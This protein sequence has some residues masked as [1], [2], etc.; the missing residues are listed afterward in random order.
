MWLAEIHVAPERSVLS[1]PLDHRQRDRRAHQA[2][3]DRHRRAGT[4][5]VPPAA[6]RRRGR[7]GRPDQ[8][9]PADLRRRAQ[10]LPAHLRG[11][12]RAL[13]R[14]PRALRRDARNPEAGVDRGPR[15]SYQGKY[16]SFDNV[17]ADPE[18]LPEAVAGDPHRRQQRRH[19]PGDRRARPR[20]LCRG[21]AR[22][23]AEL[24]PNITR[25]SR[26]LEGSR[27]I[28]ARARCFCAR[29][30]MSPKPTRRR[31][32]SRKKA[33]C[34]STATSA[35]GSRTSA[36]RA[37]VR[38]VEDR[39]ARGRRLQNITYD[40]ALRDKIIVGTPSRSPTGCSGCRR[41]RP[42]RHPGRDELRQRDPARARHE[43][44]AAAVRGGDPEVPVVTILLRRAEHPRQEHQIPVLGC[45]HPIV[46]PNTTGCRCRGRR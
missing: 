8:P 12:R 32:T 5:A 45:A 31:A 30:S 6:P 24:A 36:T 3:E 40:E 22:H 26:S 16:Y 23:P 9:R 41:A 4:A 38:A 1:A 33:S 19:L 34:I 17:S 35:S 7:D 29:R 10:R 13:W 44:A 39:A 14:E 42:R 37:G 20:R 46:P 43:V 28:P 25:V 15:F 21:A 27:A 2:H 18:A 11:L